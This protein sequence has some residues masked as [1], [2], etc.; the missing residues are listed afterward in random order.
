MSTEQFLAVGAPESELNSLRERLHEAEEVCRAIRAGEVDAVVAG[1]NDEAKRVLLLSGAYTRYRQIVEDMEQGAVTVTASGEILFANHAFA[2][3]VKRPLMDIFRTPLARYIGLE[4]RAKLDTL[5][6]GRATMR[7]TTVVLH[8]GGAPLRMSLVSASDDFTT[9]LVTNLAQRQEMD[10]AMETLEAIRRGAVDAFVLDNEQVVLLENTQTP[11]RVLVERMHE[12]AVTLDA[13]GAI[14]YANEHFLSIVAAPLGSV[15]G[16][17]LRAYVP[18]SDGAALQ[19]LL[20]AREAAQAELRL[21]RS[22]GETL[23]MHVSMTRLDGHKLFLFRDTTLHKRH[24]AA[25]ERTRKFLGMLAHEFRNILAPI[26]T[27][28]Q[29][30][31]RVEGL[32]AESRKSVEMIE[33]QAARLLSLVEDLRRVNPKE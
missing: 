31:K 18:A 16:R 29:Y 23:S 33:R 11:Y 28:V 24:Q 8:D 13:Q 32:D 12:G 26:S 15:L 9:I 20:E 25:D 27:S 1:S 30:L 22:N 3:M 14:T 2:D 4:H 10:E 19:G 7:E 21:N 5:L 6:R 17:P